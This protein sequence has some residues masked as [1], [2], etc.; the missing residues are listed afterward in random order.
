MC[1]IFHL[2]MFLE[3]VDIYKYVFSCFY[4]FSN[5]EYE[6]ALIDCVYPIF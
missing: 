4:V 2:R 3:F 6:I 5:L 1:D